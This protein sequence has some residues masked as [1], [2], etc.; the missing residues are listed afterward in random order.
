MITRWTTNE[1]LSESVEY[2]GAVGDVYSCARLCGVL[3][4]LHDVGV[5]GD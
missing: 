2:D 5:L 3:Y 1:V 4:D